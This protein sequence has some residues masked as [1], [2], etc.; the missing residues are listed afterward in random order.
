M[1]SVASSVYSPAW[2][3]MPAMPAYPIPSGTQMPQ[4]VMPAS[5]SRTSHLRSYVRS[6]PISG[7]CLRKPAGG[8][9]AHAA[10]STAGAVRWPPT[11]ATAVAQT[12]S[13]AA[14]AS[15]SASSKCMRPTLRAPPRARIARSG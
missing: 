15:R 6:H 3:G 13:M 12:S 4:T 5:R 7:T 8:G 14:R 9:A 2:S 11:L 10:T 1:S